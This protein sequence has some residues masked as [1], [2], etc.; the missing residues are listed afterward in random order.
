MDTQN[1]NPQLPPQPVAT[2]RQNISEQKPRGRNWKKWIAIY[3][4][5]G[6]ILY[7]GVYYFLLNKHPNYTP[8]TTYKTAVKPKPTTNPTANWKTY[9]NKDGAFSF[10]YP[11]ETTIA[12]YE[13][14]EGATHLEFREKLPKDAPD[15]YELAP[16]FIMDFKV[17]VLGTKTIRSVAEDKIAQAKEYASITKPL[18]TTKIND[19]SGD[20]YSSV[21]QVETTYLFLSNNDNS[22]IGINYSVNDQNNKGYIGTIN[23]ILQTFKFTNANGTDSTTNTSPDGSYTVTETQLADYNTISITN[24]KGIVIT[25]DLVKDNSD[26]IGYNIK[27]KCFCATYF[28]AWISNSTF[29]IKIGNG[30][31]EEYE[32]L[33]DASTGKVIEGTFKKIK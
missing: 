28:K 10:K 16:G 33:V 24:A 6:I 9:I 4:G 1:T 26:A 17:G 14:N 11:S 19:Y 18:T 12:P 15:G 5:V 8:Q 2:P 21:V 7:A 3:A 29:T 30:G 32:Y 25:S 20:T 13:T 22:Y 23:Q 31:G 27:F